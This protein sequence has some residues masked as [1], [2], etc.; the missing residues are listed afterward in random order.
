M[1]SDITIST[2][3][4]ALLPDFTKFSSLY[5]LQE[6]EIE[7][8]S[9]P[10]SDTGGS[11]VGGGTVGGT[12]SAAAESNS[13]TPAENGASTTAKCE[14]KSASKT[15]GKAERPPDPQTLY[16]LPPGWTTGVSL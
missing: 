16:A 15:T 4:P 5:T 1:R 11:A 2:Y 3:S 7:G 14:D 13:A 10:L 8:E 6:G 12:P 9:A